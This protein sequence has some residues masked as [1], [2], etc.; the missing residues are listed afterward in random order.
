MG[1]WA[2][3]GSCGH[4]QETRNTADRRK[5]LWSCLGAS[6]ELRRLG[7]G[8]VFGALV[9]REL[10]SIFQYLQKHYTQRTELWRSSW[11]GGWCA[12]VCA[13][14]ASLTGFC[15]SRS[16]RKP[17]DLSLEGPVS[18]GRRGQLGEGQATAHAFAEAGLTHGLR[19]DTLRLL[20]SWKNSRLWSD[21]L[22]PSDSG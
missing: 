19:A 17:S 2:K 11:K 9:R 1:P 16:R 14:D 21:R 15:I 7:V 20:T 10:L 13:G 18:E 5:R 4:P 6:L 12:D 8:N 22:E 3:F